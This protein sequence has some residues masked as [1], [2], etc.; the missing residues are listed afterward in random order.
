MFFSFIKDKICVWSSTGYIP[1]KSERLQKQMEKGDA[2]RNYVQ[3]LTL[4]E[5]NLIPN[6]EQFECPICLTDIEEEK[7]VLLREC[8]HSFCR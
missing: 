8:L 6:E 4:M 5:R 7:G 2:F 1:F 3:L